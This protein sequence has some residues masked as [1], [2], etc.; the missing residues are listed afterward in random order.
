MSN[1]K[2]AKKVYPR[3]AYILFYKD[4][5]PKVKKALGNKA[6]HYEVMK[7]IGK[8]WTDLKLSKTDQDRLR[9]YQEQAKQ[10]R[11]SKKTRPKSAYVLFF[12]DELPKVRQALGKG[13]SQHE[14]MMEIG[15]RW[16]DLK[17]LHKSQEDEARLIRYRKQAR[18]AREAYY[19]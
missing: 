7:E 18:E 12:C 11:E 8:R 14:I 10:E 19:N 2:I 6:S 3:S 16:F 13:A 9:R 17:L 5:L 1:A 4:E 15:K